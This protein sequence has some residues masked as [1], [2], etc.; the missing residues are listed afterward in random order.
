M[1]IFNDRNFDAIDKIAVLK[2]EERTGNLAVG[3]MKLGL[4][5]LNKI[6][7]FKYS[8][9]Q[10]PNKIFFFSHQRLPFLKFLL[11]VSMGNP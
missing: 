7:F 8:V 4:F 5:Y 10:F 9:L 11:L 3:H 1:F 2:Y 6:C